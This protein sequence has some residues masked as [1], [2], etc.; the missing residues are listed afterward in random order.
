MLILTFKGFEPTE[1]CVESNGAPKLPE[2]ECVV[3]HKFLEKWD[4]F[5][6]EIA[7]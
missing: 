1:V 3:R 4:K 7:L 6:V 5:T 2:P